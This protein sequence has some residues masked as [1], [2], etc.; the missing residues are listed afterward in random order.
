[1][2]PPSPARTRTLDKREAILTA[3]LDLFVERGFYGTA[4]PEIADRGGVRAGTIYRYFESKA[5]L[6]NAIYREEKTRF[7][8]LAMVDFP[9]T[10]P[11]REQFRTMWTR[12]AEFATANPQA[13]VF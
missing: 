1:M 2:R 12:M 4:V 10:A 6:V 13:F 11:T 8:R 3:A 5:A 9:A 7:G